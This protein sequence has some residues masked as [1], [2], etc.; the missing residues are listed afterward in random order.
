MCG[1]GGIGVKE[2]CCGNYVGDC[3]E[4]HAH[5]GKVFSLHWTITSLLISC[6]PEGRMV[7]EEEYSGV[8]NN[9]HTTS[10]VGSCVMI[11]SSKWLTCCCRGV[12]IDGYQP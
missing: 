12:N 7:R 4:R 5:D 11:S 9:D 1:Q 10:V 3:Y 6:G 8:I 2:L